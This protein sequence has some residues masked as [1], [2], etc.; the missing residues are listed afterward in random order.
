MASYRQ[1]RRLLN[2]VARLVREHFDP[3]V[4]AWVEPARGT[5]P[6]SL[7]VVTALKRSPRLSYE[8]KIEGHAIKARV[9]AKGQSWSL[10]T[11]HVPLRGGSSRALALAERIHAAGP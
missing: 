2:A 5:D 3:Q 10:G 8:F 7:R 4:T 6:G 11:R 9:R 1:H